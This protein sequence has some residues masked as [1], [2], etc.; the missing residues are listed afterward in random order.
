MKHIAVLIVALSILSWPSLAVGQYSVIPETHRE[1]M[2]DLAFGAVYLN[3]DGS[4]NS[5]YRPWLNTAAPELVVWA[6]SG[7]PYPNA[8]TRIENAYAQ[9]AFLIREMFEAENTPFEVHVYVVED[10]TGYTA[11]AFQRDLNGCILTPANNLAELITQGVQLPNATTAIEALE[12]I[13]M[14]CR[15]D[16]KNIIQIEAD[17]PFIEHSFLHE[18]MHLVQQ[19]TDAHPL[20]ASLWD[21]IVHILDDGATYK[22]TQRWYVEGAPQFAPILTSAPDAWINK[23]LLYRGDARFRGGI[24]Y[25]HGKILTQRQDAASLFWYYYY[26]KVLGH[27]RRQLGQAFLRYRDSGFDYQHLEMLDVADYWHDFGLAAINKPGDKTGVLEELDS[28][29]QLISESALDNAVQVQLPVPF[30]EDPVVISEYSQKYFQV[31][32]LAE[33]NN[34]VTLTL[35]DKQIPEGI[36]ISAILHRADGRWEAI[37]LDESALG[38]QWTK[39]FPVDGEPR[40]SGDTDVPYSEIAFVITNSGD[41]EQSVNLIISSQ[42]FSKYEGRGV[43]LDASST[44]YIMT[45]TKSTDRPRTGD[46]FTVTIDEEEIHTNAEDLWFRR[47]PVPDVGNESLDLKALRYIHDHGKFRGDVY[48][49]FKNLV[50]EEIVREQGQLVEK[51]KWIVNRQRRE[52][53]YDDVPNL[54]KVTLDKQDLLIM[55]AGG[56]LTAL[57]ALT[58]QIEDVVNTEYAPGTFG[59]TRRQLFQQTIALDTRQY[60][61][62]YEVTYQRGE[63]D[64]GKFVKIR[65]G[66]SSYSWLVLR[67][68]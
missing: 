27:D 66:D 57:A 63:D 48:F 14:W 52:N 36:E 49:E 5:A 2:D 53:F 10:I 33:V 35:P 24:A 40:L 42:L 55:T 61:Q 15:E 68:K 26:A 7:Q 29:F 47:D 38:Q 45:G 11:R 23:E 41:V 19:V 9:G 64:N 31:T 1:V 60:G 46:G 50:P 44:Q 58:K 13:G 6:P 43:E 18:Y 25:A 37:R 20:E 67:E 56:G 12:G 51:G 17:H 34:Y 39:R 30:G 62:D 4:E 59:H 8:R 54:F 32:S 28:D 65:M 21:E 3:D 16:L 22:D